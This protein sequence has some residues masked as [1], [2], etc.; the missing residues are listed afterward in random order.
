MGGL[1]D[2]AGGWSRSVLMSTTQPQAPLTP[3]QAES[4]ERA[5]VRLEGQS[6]PRMLIRLVERWSELGHPPPRVRLAQARAFLSLRLMDRAWV[7]LKEVGD[8]VGDDPELLALTAEMFIERGWPIRARKAVSTALEQDPANPRLHLLLRR[9]HAPPAQPP[10]NAR[11]LER[12]GA[13]PEQLELA[14]RFLCAGSFLRGRSILEKLRRLRGPWSGRVED[15]LWGLSGDFTSGVPDPVAAAQ[16]ILSTA[17]LKELGDMTDH[18]E[19]TAHGE[20]SQQVVDGKAF[21]SLFRRVEGEGSGGRDW[22]GEI[23]RISRLADLAEAAAR[24]RED[25]T[26]GGDWSEEHS[27]DTQIQVVVQ[28][29][30]G[31]PLHRRVQKE[32]AYDLK[33]SLDLREYQ[34]SMGMGVGPVSDLAGPDVPTA[35]SDLADFLQDDGEFLE[36]EDDALIVMT[37][38]EPDSSELPEEL[39]VPSG[40]IEVVERPIVP[41]RPAPPAVEVPPEPTAPGPAVHEPEPRRRA[42]ARPRPGPA[43]LPQGL[44]WFTD[45]RVI[46]AVILAAVLLLLFFIGGRLYEWKVAH[47]VWAETEAVLAQG[48]YRELLQEESRLEARLKAGE[49]PRGPLLAAYAVM[50]LVLYGEYTGG[51]PRFVAANDSIQLAVKVGAPGS[52]VGL[53]AAWRS[54][55]QGDIDGAT[56]TL[57]QVG[58]DGAEAAHLRSLVA[59]DAGRLEQAREAAEAAVTAAPTSARYQLGLASVCQ[60]LG[61]SDCVEGAFADASQASASHPSVRLAS[62]QYGGG[63]VASRLASLQRF[64]EDAGPRA[65]RHG[66]QAHA[67]AADLHLQRGD[68]GAARQALERSIATDPDNPTLLYRAAAIRLASN[69]PREGMRNLQSCLAL[70]P[71]DMACNGALVQARL[72]LDRVDEAAA[73]IE[74]LPGGQQAQPR[75]HLF[76][77]WVEAAGR[78]DAAAAR[79]E[80]GAYEAAGGTPDGEVLYLTGLVLALEGREEEAVVSFVEAARWVSEELDPLQRRLSGRALA[81]AARQSTGKDA[82]LHA[83]AALERSPEDPGVHIQLG[84]FEEGLQDRR[85]AGA[86]FD[87]AV[88]LSPQ[89]ALAHYHRGQFYLDATRRAERRQYLVA[90]RQYLALEPSGPRAERVARKLDLQ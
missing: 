46:S 37:R 19:V 5:V 20:D 77:A 48:G 9:S 14:E 33:E 51:E 43:P 16:A 31:A 25:T 89:M 85:A 61:D 76:R 17:P 56:Q 70:R 50:E 2:L 21:P 66:G 32:G 10:G 54:Y 52:V 69:S 74:A 27:A 45:L 6:D 55:L 49:R 8:T 7:R 36:E 59:L 60:R 53:A 22:D 38:R 84:Y 11:E 81:W 12:T 90:W 62:V 24:Q 82:H 72:A 3:A 42:P 63:D 83:V 28:K 58:D 67:L 79:A 44:G 13:P 88:E 68:E 18:S 35:D 57:G 34:A 65:P 4:L 80:L 39:D 30:A 87:R 40:P 29:D 86:H 78:E 15:L 41:L 26:D 75:M 73:G 71:L 23:T 47:G 64:L 1:A